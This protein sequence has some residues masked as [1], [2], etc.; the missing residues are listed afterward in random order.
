MVNDVCASSNSTLVSSIDRT[1]GATFT[2]SES[3]VS[4]P[5]PLEVVLHHETASRMQH[6]AALANLWQQLLQIITTSTDDGQIDCDRALTDIVTLT[7]KAFGVDGC[8]IALPDMAQPMSQIA[9]WSKGTSHLSVQHLETVPAPLV[10]LLNQAEPVNLADIETAPAHHTGLDS[11]HEHAALWQVYTPPG[12]SYQPV[13]AVLGIRLQVQGHWGG[14]LNLVQSHPRTWTDSE[15]A[16]LQAVAHQIASVVTHLLQQQQIHRQLQYQQVV[17]QLTL[18]IH[19]TSDLN[20]ILKLATDG[21]AKALH[22]QHGMLLRLKHWDALFRDRSPTQIPKIRV[23]VA[24]EQPQNALSG[25]PINSAIANPSPQSTPP[26]ASQSFWM[27]ECALCQ[28]AFFHPTTPIVMTDQQQRPWAETGATAAAVFNL[29]TLPAL[30]LT[31]LESKGTVLGFLVF[32]HDRA[33]VWHS[34]ELELVQIV[35][36]QVSTAIIQTET[37]RQ[38]Q[39]LVEKRTAELRE[40]LA[41]QAKLYERTRQQIDQLRHLNQMKD[42]FLSTVNHELRTPLTSMTMAIRM[43]RQT[44]LESDRGARYLD[45]LEQQCAQETNLIND[46]LAL[47]ELESNQ[48][49]MHLQTID[50]KALV[51]DLSRMFGQKWAAKG[52]T[53]EIRLP[54]SKVHLLSDRD[55]L[56]RILLELLTNAG[57]YAEPNSCVQLAMKQV[58][59]ATDNQI[60]VSVRNLGQ[61]IAPDELPFIFDKFKRCQGA[62]QNAIQGTGLGLALVKSLVQHLNGSLTASSCQTEDT[63]SCETCFTLTLPQ[64]YDTSKLS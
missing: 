9:R 64:T 13:K 53:L 21:T 30:L 29:D 48:V 5:E 46:L 62:T 36:A 22:V 11:A 55:S 2:V 32:Q 28:Q 49:A 35:S 45:I 41:V 34:K 44:G 60:I 18:A 14:V 56:H 33:R 57:K 51:Q 16:A 39:A 20:D 3:L 59:G 24:Y 61:G 10:E 27:S 38:V 42:E 12:M 26:D 43:L 4:S 63:Q 23:N 47:Q 15:I 19:N 6:P 8:M 52:L 58:I 54:K 50:L 37:L 40:S 31:P 17:N 1:S 25:A 7:G